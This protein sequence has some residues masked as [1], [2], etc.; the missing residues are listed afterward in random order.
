[1]TNAGL[2]ALGDLKSL[3]T[4]NLDSTKVTAAAV[5]ELR[6]ARPDLK[7]SASFLKR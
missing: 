4:L 2:T 1:V 7:I 5:A 3:R 6:K